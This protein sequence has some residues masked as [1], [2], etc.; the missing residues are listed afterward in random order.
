MNRICPICL[1]KDWGTESGKIFPFPVVVIYNNRE[2]YRKDKNYYAYGQQHC[3][4]V[5]F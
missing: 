1:G 5:I 3:Y 2:R 4:D